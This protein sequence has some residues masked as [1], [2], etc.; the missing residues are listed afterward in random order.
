VKISSIVNVTGN[1]GKKIKNGLRGAKDMM[2]DINMTK[3]KIPQIIRI[4]QHLTGMNDEEAMSS[5]NM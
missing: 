5:W 2:I 1:P 3:A 4:I